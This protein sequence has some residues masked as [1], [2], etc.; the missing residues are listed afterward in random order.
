[1]TAIKHLSNELSGDLCLITSGGACARDIISE[2]CDYLQTGENFQNIPST[3][4]T[5]A[6]HNSPC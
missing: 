4:I 6:R 2:P 3:L 5:S 1:M